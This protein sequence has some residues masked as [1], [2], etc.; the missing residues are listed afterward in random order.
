MEEVGILY[1]YEIIEKIINIEWN[2][3]TKVSNIG[4]RSY[5]QD[6]RD[7]FIISRK[8]YFS[9]YNREILES[10]LKDLENNSSKG[11][12]LPTQKYG[13]MMKYTNYEYFKTIESSLLPV[14]KEKQ[15]LIDLIML[16]CD[17]WLLEISNM[18]I[19]KGDRK[20]FSDSDTDKSTSVQTYL[21]GEYTSYSINTLN[22]ILIYFTL[23]YFEKSNLLYENLKRLSNYTIVKIVT[24]VLA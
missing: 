14:T 10:Y 20:L 24:E 11:I 5:C 7:A 9:I 4:K 6:K 13:Y 19:Y 12:S 15:N 1:M 21:R 17:A 18:D 2:L 3:F 23:K 16:I 22:K 8:A